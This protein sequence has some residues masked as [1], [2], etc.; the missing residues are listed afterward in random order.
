[1]KNSKELEDLRQL[2]KKYKIEKLIQYVKLFDN[3]K[4]PDE[5]EENKNDISQ[6]GFVDHL[7][8]ENDQ[9]G[10]HFEAFKIISNKA[11]SQT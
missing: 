1:L 7:T 10:L 6:G 11:W 3:E 4:L 9:V 5:G 2:S 8:N